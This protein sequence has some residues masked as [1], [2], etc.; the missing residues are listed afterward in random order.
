[1]LDK[2]RALDIKLGLDEYDL[3]R[4]VDILVEQWDFESSSASTVAIQ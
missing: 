3:K 2:Y 1:M 4:R